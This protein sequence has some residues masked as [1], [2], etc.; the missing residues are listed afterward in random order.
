M[1]E[2]GNTYRISWGKYGSNM[3]FGKFDIGGRI[4]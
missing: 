1:R 4:I 3:H 2:V